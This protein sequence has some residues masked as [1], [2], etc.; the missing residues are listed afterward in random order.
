VRSLRPLKVKPKT[1]FKP[2]CVTCMPAGLNSPT[3]PALQRKNQLQR[4]GAACQWSLWI[5]P[6]CNSTTGCD[7]QPRFFLNCSRCARV[8]IASRFTHSSP[9]M[10]AVLG[11]ALHTKSQWLQEGDKAHQ[12][13]DTAA[14]TASPLEV[15]ASAAS[16]CLPVTLLKRA[17]PLHAQSAATF[18]NAAA[19]VSGLMARDS[20]CTLLQVLFDIAATWWCV[21]SDRP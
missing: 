12:H 3:T 4:Y 9:P 6:V 18:T 8:A 20:G 2:L 13:T 10:A 19:S 5:L 14:D 16:L 15:A 11:L 1:T 21:T 17:L 7:G